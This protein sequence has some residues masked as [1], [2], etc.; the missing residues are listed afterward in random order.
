MGEPTSK[1]TAITGVQVWTGRSNEPLRRVTIRCEG[2]RIHAM[3][4]GPGLTR[5]ARVVNF[6]NMFAIPG[7][8]DC[9]VHMALDPAKNVA[10][11]QLQ[12]PREL[13][14]GMAQRAER[15]VRCGITTARDL[16]AADW[17][18]LTL[19]DQIAAGDA[20]GPRLL[21]AGQPLTTRSGT[22]TLTSSGTPIGPG[23]SKE[24]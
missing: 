20:P 1:A 23:G 14:L 6:E 17:S 5:G 9:H 12:S 13:Q 19:R 21:C 3:G 15:M 7:L 22:T 4:D 8:I 24:G 18:A 16:G 2:E 10:E 11:Q